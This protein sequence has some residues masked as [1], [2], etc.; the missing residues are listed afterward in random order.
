MSQGTLGVVCMNVCMC[1]C[2]CASVHA[3]MCACM[4]VYNPNSRARSPHHLPGWHHPSTSS[5]AE[6]LRHLHLHVHAFLQGITQAGFES[7]GGEER[8]WADHSLSYSSW[9]PTNVSVMAQINTFA[10]TNFT[11][12]GTIANGTATLLVCV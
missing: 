3:I 4:R 6:N 8:R 9:L 5:P 1:A 10:Q 2:M 11:T 12:D 7:R